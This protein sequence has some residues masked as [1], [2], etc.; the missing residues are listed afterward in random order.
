[1]SA[2]QYILGLGSYL[3]KP[4]GILH[5][6]GHYLLG[7]VDAVLVGKDEVDVFFEKADLTQAFISFLSDVRKEVRLHVFTFA[8]YAMAQYMSAFEI[9]SAG[10]FRAGGGVSHNIIKIA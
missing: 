6:V 8:F 10:Q 2:V 5:Q 1:M 7:D 3:L 9:F 4:G